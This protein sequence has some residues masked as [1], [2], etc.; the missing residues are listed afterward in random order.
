[1]KWSARVKV[2]NFIPA[3]M[4]WRGLVLSKTI[5]VLSATTVFSRCRAQRNHHQKKGNPKVAFDR[6]G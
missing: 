3:A 2:R 1:M 6:A 5:T 4:V